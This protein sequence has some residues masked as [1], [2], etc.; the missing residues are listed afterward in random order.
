M[1]LLLL[2][3]RFSRLPPCHPP[4]ASP[5]RMWE[6][7]AEPEYPPETH[8]GF[9]KKKNSIWKAG[10][11][12]PI[13][14]PRFPLLDMK[15]LHSFRADRLCICDAREKEKA[16]LSL[17]PAA[18]APTVAAAVLLPVPRPPPQFGPSISVCLSTISVSL[19]GFHSLSLHLSSCFTPSFSPPHPRAAG[20]RT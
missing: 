14:K 16:T 2:L 13:T 7:P 9:E 15:D 8:L 12:D 17:T 18:K 10:L 5:Q 1:L 3:S 19:S 11:S 6:M 20:G 4:P